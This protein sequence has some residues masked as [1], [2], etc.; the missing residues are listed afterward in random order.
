[1]E[2][3]AALGTMMSSST[4]EISTPLGVTVTAASFLS[5][6]QHDCFEK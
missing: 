5:E 4:H 3:M 2:S 6:I 1:M